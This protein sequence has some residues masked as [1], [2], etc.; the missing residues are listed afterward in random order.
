MTRRPRIY[1]AGPMSAPDGWAF[2]QNCRRGEDVGWAVIQAGGAPIVPHSMG[3]FFRGCA[4]FETWMEVDLALLAACDGIVLLPGWE[5]SR[6]AIEEEQF[7]WANSIPRLVFDR[8]IGPIADL[9]RWIES[10][11]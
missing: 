9:R 7:A 10:L 5:V 4:S 8:E 2:E 11:S 3:R 6:G 1:I